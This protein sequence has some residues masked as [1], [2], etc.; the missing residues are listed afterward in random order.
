MG[1]RSSVDRINVAAPEGKSLQD[2]AGL[3]RAGPGPAA[4]V[5]HRAQSASCGPGTA[6]ESDRL[7]YSAGGTLEVLTARDFV[8]AEGLQVRRQELDVENRDAFGEQPFNGGRE[9]DFGGIPHSVK[10]AFSRE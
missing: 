9:G 3:S 6:S 1:S 4:G 10:H 8:S 2:L 7:T 5:K